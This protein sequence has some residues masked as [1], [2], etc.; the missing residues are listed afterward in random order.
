MV[1]IN[2]DD[3]SVENFKAIRELQNMGYSD[4]QIQK[5]YEKIYEA[6][7]DCVGTLT[8]LDVELVEQ[9]KEKSND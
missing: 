3:K 6:L 2:L 9:K 4:E 1:T 8:P 5:W 7:P